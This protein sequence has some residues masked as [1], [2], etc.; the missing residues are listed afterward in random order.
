MP[1]GFIQSIEELKTISQPKEILFGTSAPV[2]STASQ[3]FKS[4]AIPNYPAPTQEI[5]VESVYIPPIFFIK[6]E[7][8]NNNFILTPIMGKIFS[9]M[10]VLINEAF[11]TESNITSVERV[12]MKFAKQATNV[13]FSF[14]TSD[15]IPKILDLPPLPIDKIAL[16]LNIDYIYSDKPTRIDF[17]N[18]ESF[19]SSPLSYISINKSFNTAKLKD[20][21]P[22]VSL[23]AYNEI[24][25]QWDT[26]DKLQRYK[27]FDTDE[28]CGYIIELKH[29][30]KFAVGGT[31]PPIDE[32]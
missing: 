1:Q 8:S 5:A 7:N 22:D 20:G 24:N 25:Q 17:S 3:L 21:C 11:S 4:Y 28:K 10:S 18:P 29:F 14:G 31:Q 32:T 26:L 9:N 13:G 30:S 6:Q 16:F 23:Y 12:E 2:T 15:N 19:I 27:L